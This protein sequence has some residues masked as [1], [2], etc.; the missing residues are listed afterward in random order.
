MDCTGNLS[1]EQFIKLHSADSVVCNIWYGFDIMLQNGKQNYLFDSMLW[2]CHSQV[3]SQA[4]S[5]TRWTLDGNLMVS[6]Y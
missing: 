1:A 5:G 4:P 3:I 2:F 6:A